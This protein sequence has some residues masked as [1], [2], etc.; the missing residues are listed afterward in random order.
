MSKWARSF[1]VVTFSADS[2]AAKY[3]MPRIHLLL[4]KHLLLVH[5]FGDVVALW[6]KAPVW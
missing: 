6:T 5:F 2:F 4:L 3:V 1:Q